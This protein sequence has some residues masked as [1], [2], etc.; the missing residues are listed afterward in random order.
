MHAFYH[1]CHLAGPSKCALYAPSPEEVQARVDALL[2]RIKVSPVIVQPNVITG[3][4][5]PEIIS[6]SRVRRLIST[7]LYQPVRMFARTATA[8]A[9]LEKGDGEPLYQY[10]LAGSDP[11]SL[12]SLE[13]VPPTEPASG[14][15]E[16][17]G[18]AFP[19][20][21]CSDAEPSNLTIEEME[22]HAERLQEISRAAGS[23]LV[24]FR[25]ACVGRTVRPKWRFAGPFGG[26]TSFP[27]LFVANAAD[28]VTP[29]VSARNNSA[30]FPGSTVLVQNSYGH[31]SLSTASTCTARYIRNYFQT[32]VLPAPD[33][34]C[35]PDVAPFDL[36]VEGQQDSDADEDDAEL[37]KA[38]QELARDA[39]WAGLFKPP[40]L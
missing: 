38:I 24:L 35:E 22:L 26:N 18:D 9:A 20:I 39:N 36:E 5:I 23:V 37:S 14:S 4:E 21:L 30:A 8:L 28:N 11:S 2:E 6:Y 25:M 31:T 17:T 3:P 1:F 27:I 10:Y 32:G 33:A 12:C 40:H 19:A 29:L 16:D 7:T 15:D 34:V 13:T